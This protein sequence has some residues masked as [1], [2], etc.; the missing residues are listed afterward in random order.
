MPKK[1]VFRMAG[2]PYR[3]S[4][5]PPTI[6]K[7]IKVLDKQKLG[8]LYTSREVATLAGMTYVAFKN[9]MADPALNNYKCMSEERFFLQ[10]GSEETMT[11]FKKI[12]EKSK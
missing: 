11:E 2:V 3:P 8:D 7:V 1:V 9:H 12:R 10:W 6:L 4:K 5:L